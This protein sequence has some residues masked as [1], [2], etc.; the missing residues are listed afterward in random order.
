M[1]Y[2]VLPVGRWPLSTSTRDVL[3]DKELAWCVCV[4][5]SVSVCVLYVCLYVCVCVCVCVSECVFIIAIFQYCTILVIRIALYCA[6]LC[7]WCY[8]IY[9]VFY[10]VG[11]LHWVGYIV[12]IGC[13]I[14]LSSPFITISDSIDI[15][16]VTM[17]SSFRKSISCRDQ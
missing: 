17:A 8:T 16:D 12:Y 7:N 6:V 13:V 9:Y 2:L 1:K 14:L 15:C 4:C 5:V 11:V 3:Q 10:T